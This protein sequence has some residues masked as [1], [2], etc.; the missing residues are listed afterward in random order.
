MKSVNSPEALPSAG[1]K[2]WTIDIMRFMFIS[3]T[4]VCSFLGCDVQN[5]RDRKVISGQKELL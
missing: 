3:L 5:K 1:L 2:G 4:T